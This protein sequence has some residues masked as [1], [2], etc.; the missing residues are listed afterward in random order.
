MQK[1]YKIKCPQCG[2]VKE[3][4]DK[5]SK[6]CSR[7]CRAKFYNERIPK[8]S[9]EHNRKVSEGLK[10]FWKNKREHDLDYINKW[11]KRSVESGNNSQKGKHKNPESLKDISTRTAAKI[12]KRLHIGCSNCGWKESTCDIHHIKGK[13]IKN[14]NDHDNLC[15]LCPNCHRLVHT[16][17][18]KSEMLI[19]L[20]EQIKDDWKKY[21]YG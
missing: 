15:C 19:P 21:Y 9:E 20:S 14:A 13:K 2:I 11:K 3:T 7:S 12:L 4:V 16:K 18:I 17:I 6:F 8:H 5:R 1:M 10:K